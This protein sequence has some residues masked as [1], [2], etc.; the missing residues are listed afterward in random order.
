MEHQD[1]VLV[2]LLLRVEL[3]VL[4]NQQELLTEVAVVD[5]RLLVDQEL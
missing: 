4:N 1:Q 3:V 5:L 2:E